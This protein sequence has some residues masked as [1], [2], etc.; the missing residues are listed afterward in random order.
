MRFRSLAVVLGL[1]MIGAS[2]G[3]PPSYRV[4][5]GWPTLPTNTMLYEVSAVAADSHDHVF[6]LMRGGR[7]WPD[8]G[9]FDTTAIRGATVLVFDARN[10][11]VVSRWPNGI[12]AL[13]HSITVDDQDN[14]WVSDVAWHQVFKFSHDGKL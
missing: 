5:H 11:D 2:S 4:V 14:V 8:A 12:F 13:P 7:K 1:C 10:G 6:V 9:P 3:A